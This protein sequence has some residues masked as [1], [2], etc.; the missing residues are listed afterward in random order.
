MQNPYSVSQLNSYIK[1]MFAQDYMLRSIYVKG[2]ISNVKYHSSNHIYFTLKDGGGQISSVMFSSYRSRGLHFKLENGMQVIVLGSVEVWEAGGKY[3]L[4]AKEIH[5]DGI[6]ALY[7]RFEQLKKELGEMGMFDPSYKQPVPKYP[8]TIG[9]VT[10]PGGA[11]IQDIINIT[12]RRNPY[13]QLI[14]YP[15]TVQGEGAAESIVSGIRALERYGVDVIIVGRGGGS[16]EEL[17]AFNEEAVARAIFDCRIPIVSAVGHETDTTISDFVADLRA[18]TP[19][20]AAELTVWPVS[21]LEERLNSLNEHLTRRIEGRISIERNRLMSKKLRLEAQ[22]PKSKLFEKRLYL[23]SARDL[24]DDQMKRLIAGKRQR[25]SIAAERFEGLSPLRR[26]KSGYALVEAEGKIVT[27]TSSVQEGDSLL[28]YLLNK[29]I[30]ATVNR[31]EVV[32]REKQWK[33]QTK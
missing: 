24:L 32:D 15:A 5:M 18:P 4:Y 30:E 11:A 3:Q 26:L 31:I 17:W 19:S 23:D 8:G 20:A 22:N 28:L 13:V 27:E 33:R 29:N 12:K 7:E 16:I 1:N 21:E 9:V 6:G 2:E 14:L 10:A 25:L